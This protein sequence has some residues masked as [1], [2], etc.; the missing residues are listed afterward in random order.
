MIIFKKSFAPVGS[1]VAFFL[2][3]KL[4]PT[5]SSAI[6]SISLGT[7]VIPNTASTVTEFL[8]SG[9]SFHL[10]FSAKNSTPTPP[11]P[12]SASLSARHRCVDKEKL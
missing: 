7:A 3:Q 9:I 1:F 6:L 10:L 5:Y 11:P 2:K 8:L 4:T 12:P